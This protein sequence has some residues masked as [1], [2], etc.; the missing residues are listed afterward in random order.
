VA[1]SESGQ[2]FVSADAEEWKSYP[3]PSTGLYGITQADGMFVAVGAEGSI[4]TSTN[5][6]DWIART[7]GT[8][9]Q[10]H[11]IARGKGLFVATGRFGTVLTSPDGLE[12]TNA[13]S[14]NSSDYW[15]GVAYGNGM[16]VI[17][18]SSPFE[19]NLSI[20]SSNG[21]DWHYVVLNPGTTIPVADLNAIAFGA[22]QF[23]AVGDDGHAFSSV[24]G[25]EWTGHS[26]GTHNNLRNA[27]YADGAFTVIGNG[28]L[29]MQSAQLIP[30]LQEVKH[31]DEG[32]QLRVRAVPNCVHR[33]QVSGDLKSWQDIFT[34]QNTAELTS[35]SD[36]E[37]LLYPTRFYRVQIP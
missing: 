1:V 35:Y 15:K 30:R 13:L 16:F 12:W 28:G 2:A 26:P 19:S 14:G 7:S 34:F 21:I 37:G 33:L 23:L 6:S 22:G 20:V 18:G 25:T 31:S 10:L 29:I 3:T 8:S 5:G 27:L 36:L 11:G 24:D 32:I 4:V 9:N 17:V